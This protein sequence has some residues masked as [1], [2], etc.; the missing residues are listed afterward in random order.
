MLLKEIVEESRLPT[1]KIPGENGSEV[2]GFVKMVFE[3]FSED[4]EKG[5]VYMCGHGL[6]TALS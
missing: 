3:T 5:I 1:T 2:A 4:F 6:F